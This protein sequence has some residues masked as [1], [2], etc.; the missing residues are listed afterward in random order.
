MN[1]FLGLASNCNHPDLC[2]L[3][4]YDYRPEPLA[5]SLTSIK[6]KRKE[7]EKLFSASMRKAESLLL[8][9]TKSF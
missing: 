7:K 6:K 1:Y 8:T 5:P 3:R 9:T 2:L 4:S